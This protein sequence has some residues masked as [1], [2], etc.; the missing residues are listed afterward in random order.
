M[1]HDINVMTPVDKDS[2][3]SKAFEEWKKS[4]DYSNSLKWAVIPEHSE[5]TLWN[6]FMRGF[7]SAEEI[8]KDE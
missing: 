7:L 5:G 1:D 6:A 3:L 8:K 2:P 4:E